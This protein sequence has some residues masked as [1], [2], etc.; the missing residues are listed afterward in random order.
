MQPAAPSEG[1]VLDLMR[2]IDDLQ[3]MMS[4]R[5]ESLR[6][7][8]GIVSHAE[9]VRANGIP[10]E[11]RTAETRSSTPLGRRLHAQLD[12]LKSM[13]EMLCEMHSNLALP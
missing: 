10:Q 7:R 11:V 8:L 9:A 4:A 3:P 12:A 5:I 2:S 13:D 1:E 6:Q